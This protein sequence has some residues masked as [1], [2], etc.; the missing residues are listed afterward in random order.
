MEGSHGP[1][2]YERVPEQFR[3][4][5][6]DC[7]T[8]E[9]QK[10]SEEEIRNAYDNTIL[11]TDHVLASLIRHLEGLTSDYAPHCYTLRIT[12]NLWEK[13]GY[14]CTACPTSWHPT[15]RLTSLLC[16]G[17]QTAW[18]MRGISRNC[19]GQT[20]H[21]SVSHDNISHTLTGLMGI[22]STLYHSELG[23][24]HQ[25]RSAGIIGHDTSVSSR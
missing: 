8:A 3:K 14:S 2:Y 16:F 13:T 15:L 24:T 12:G 17:Y 25:C 11:Y 23:L 19:L 22:Q 18:L 4:F 7:R 6:P 5:T 9:L 1:A 21:E 10:C 20:T